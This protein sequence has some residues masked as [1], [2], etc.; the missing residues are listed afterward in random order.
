MGRWHSPFLAAEFPAAVAATAGEPGMTSWCRKAGATAAIVLAC[1]MTSRAAERELVVIGG[2][3]GAV[4]TTRTAGA[5]G[6]KYG[7]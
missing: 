7:F 1:G 3:K 4:L 5:E 6:N 2:V